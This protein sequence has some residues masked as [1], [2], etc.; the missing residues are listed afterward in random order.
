MP[1]IS[2]K[3]VVA[4]RKSLSAAGF[5]ESL[6]PGRSPAGLSLSLRANS[7]IPNG[8]ESTKWQFRGGYLEKERENLLQRQ[9]GSFWCDPGFS[10]GCHNK[11]LLIEVALA[12]CS[13][14]RWQKEREM[15]CFRTAVLWRQQVTLRLAAFPSLDTNTV[16]SASTGRGHTWTENLA[17]HSAAWYAL[18]HY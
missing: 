8:G 4:G 9:R 2:S 11:L 3:I 1:P 13:V 5:D 18:H 15:R 6:F 7:F 17:S 16:S 14:S 10:L 12:E